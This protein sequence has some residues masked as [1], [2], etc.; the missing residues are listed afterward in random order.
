MK[1]PSTKAEPEVPAHLPP[2]HDRVM[3][4]DTLLHNSVASGAQQRAQS[5]AAALVQCFVTSGSWS[6]A[7][8]ETLHLSS[9]R[10]DKQKSSIFQLEGQGY[11]KAT[12]AEKQ[13]LSAACFCQIKGLAVRKSML[14]EAIL[15]RMKNFKRPKYPE[16]LRRIHLKMYPKIFQYPEKVQLS[17]DCCTSTIKEPQGLTTSSPPPVTS[18]LNS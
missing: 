9:R 1:D 17:P 14:E 15:K 12:N 10:K 2:K 5:R 8:T 4:K 11:T 6:C 13:S 16:I 3:Q 18:L 7:P